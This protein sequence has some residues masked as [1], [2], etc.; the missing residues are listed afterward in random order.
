[1]ST[2]SDPRPVPTRAARARLVVTTVGLL[3]SCRAPGAAEGP[4]PD[5]LA[6]IST[7]IAAIESA[8]ERFARNN[9]GSYPDSLV[10]LV[11]PDAYG[12]TYLNRTTVPRDP[13]QKEY[14]YQAPGPGRPHPRVFTLGRD[15]LPGGEGEDRDLD[16]AAIREAPILDRGSAP[17]QGA[18]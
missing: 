2:R 9:M 1:M 16:G 12:A 5:L 14:G 6:S 11:M 18:R 10:V 8:L 4:S 13:W 3:A 15:G 7:D 17:R